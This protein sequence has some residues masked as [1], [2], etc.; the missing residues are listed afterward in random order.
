MEDKNN[1]KLVVIGDFGTGKTCI[2]N[3]LLGKDFDSKSPATTGASYCSK[4]LI[5]E[6]HSF[7]ADIWDTCGAEAYK[8]LTKFFLQG[9]KGA[10]IVYEINSK[11]SFD[12]IDSWIKILK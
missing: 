11:C 3:S 8:S 6:G 7:T 9:A 1:I 12:N 5:L 4:S 2:I 10:F